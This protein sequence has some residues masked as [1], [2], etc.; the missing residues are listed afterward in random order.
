MRFDL[1]SRRQGRQKLNFNYSLLLL[2]GK[3]Y[4]MKLLFGL[5]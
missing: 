2:L 1:L 5:L 3:L 4:T